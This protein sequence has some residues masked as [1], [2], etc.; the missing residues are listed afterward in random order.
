MDLQNAKCF[1]RHSD[2]DAV[3]IIG[4]SS[5]GQVVLGNSILNADTINSFSNTLQS[6]EIL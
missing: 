1:T 5:A 6:L 2:V 3:H 4:H